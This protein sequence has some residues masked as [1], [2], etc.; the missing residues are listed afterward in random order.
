MGYISSEPFSCWLQKASREST[1]LSLKRSSSSRARL[2]FSFASAEYSH[3][4]KS[5]QDLIV[6]LNICSEHLSPV[7]TKTRQGPRQADAWAA[8]LFSLQSKNWILSQNPLRGSDKK[9]N[10]WHSCKI[11]LWRPS[12]HKWISGYERNPMT[13]LLATA[14]SWTWCPR[15]HLPAWSYLLLVQIHGFNRWFFLTENLTYPCYIMHSMCSSYAW[16]NRSRW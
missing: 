4:F 14:A 7:Q 10:I 3:N 5:Y 1:W 16:K 11:T 6:S 8:M 13:W 9:M 12:K 2:W 15:R